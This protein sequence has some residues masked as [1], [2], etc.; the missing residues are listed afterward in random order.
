MSCFIVII[1]II[2]VSVSVCVWTCVNVKKKKKTTAG[3]TETAEEGSS[4]KMLP[5]IFG[6]AVRWW[7][8][9]L[10]CDCDCECVMWDCPSACLSLS[11]CLAGFC[12]SLE[13]ES[14]TV[15]QI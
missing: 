4:L 10:V 3:D 11:V 7:H 12:A 15:P 13:T 14:G 1:F 8:H 2:A 9:A 6:A 5:Y